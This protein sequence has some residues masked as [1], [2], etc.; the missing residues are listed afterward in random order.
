MSKTYKGYELAEALDSGL[1]SKEQ[2]VTGPDYFD[3]TIGFIL[4]DVANNFLFKDFEIIED[5]QEIDIQKELIMSAEYEDVN[6]YDKY[7]IKANRLLI[8]KLVQAV[9]QLD[10]KMKEN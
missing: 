2:K 5:E 9:K 8:N 1:F 10:K 6:S 7:S 4:K 3:C